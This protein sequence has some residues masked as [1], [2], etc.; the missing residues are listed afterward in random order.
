MFLKVA[1][2]DLT[3]L[4]LTFLPFVLSL[5]LCFLLWEQFCDSYYEIHQQFNVLKELHFLK[6]QEDTMQ[7]QYRF[8]F[9]VI[10]HLD[11]GLN[12]Q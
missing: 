6:N 2:Q 10:I 4:I 1:L 5:I 7:Q 3:L 12:Q 9:F 8:H 11:K